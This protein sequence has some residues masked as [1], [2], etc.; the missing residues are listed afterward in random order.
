[1]TTCKQLEKSHT[2][3]VCELLDEE[4]V[5]VMEE[6]LRGCPT[7]VHKIKSLQKVFSLTEEAGEAPIPSVILDNI[8]MRVY[9]RLA[10]ESPRSKPVRFFESLPLPTVKNGSTWILRSA[11]ATC[12]LA[13]GIPITVTFFDRDQS[14]DVP[15]GAISETPR[16]R[17][18]A[19]R[20]REIQDSRTEALEARHLKDNDQLAR[21]LLALAERGP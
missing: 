2:N 14:L 3:Y 4:Q 7:C 20:Q 17:I 8:E 11:I 13:I 18:E 10:A 12:V 15:I 1:M 16:E 5:A 6:H 9:K 21:L 19:Y